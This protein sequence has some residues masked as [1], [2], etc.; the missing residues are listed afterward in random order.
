M[1]KSLASEKEVRLATILKSL[2]ERELRAYRYF[3]D[4][5]QPSVS[6]DKAEELFALYQRGSSCE[7]IRRLFPQFGLG[8][9]VALR[10]M[11]DWDSRRTTEIDTIRR[12]VPAKVATAQMETQEFLANLL[13]AS[14]KRFNDALKLYIA[15]GNTQYLVDAKVPIPGNFKELDALVTLYMKIAGTDTKKVEVSV[16]GAVKHA[17][18]RVKPE[19]AEALMDELLGDEKKNVQDAEFTEHKEEEEPLALEPLPNIE[20]PQTP[21]EMEKFLVET[22][23][24]PEKAKQVV[25]SLGKKGAN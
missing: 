10:V 17:V 3:V 1:T 8:Q 19:E 12:E 9:V 24:D 2:P 23:M 25:A 14:N 6:D 15:T 7:E 5:N 21:E 4:K 16:T 20:H 18:E 22:G 13:H 11:N